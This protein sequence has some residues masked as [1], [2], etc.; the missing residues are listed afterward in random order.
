[1]LFLNK[2]HLQDINTQQ[3]EVLKKLINFIKEQQKASELI[4]EHQLNL[5]R[6]YKQNII[7]IEGVIKMLNSNAWYHELYQC[8]EGYLTNTVPLA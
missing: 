4:V 7:E 5:I 2:T 8:V 6:F 1:M 3:E